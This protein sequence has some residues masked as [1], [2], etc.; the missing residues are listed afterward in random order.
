MHAGHSPAVN[1][2]PMTT[3]QNRLS[4]VSFA[5]RHF[6]TLLLVAYVFSYF[7]PTLGQLIRKPIFHASEVSCVNFMLGFV[8]LTLG[9][10]TSFQ[11][12]RLR[13]PSNRVQDCLELVVGQAK[14]V[15]F[16]YLVRFVVALFVGMLTS[17]VADSYVGI[18]VGFVLLC[19]APTAASS[20]SW[21]L[22]LDAS[23]TTTIAL[24]LGTTILSLVLGTGMLATVEF[25]ATSSC[26]EDLARLKQTFSAS[27][28]LPWV[29]APLLAGMFWRNVAPISA[30]KCRSVGVQLNPL[31]LL[32]LNYANAA[33]SFP[34]LANSFSVNQS[35]IVV[36][37]AVT[38]FLILASVSH[39]L[40]QR[41]SSSDAE[42]VSQTIGTSMSN[43]GLLLMMATLALPGRLDVHLPI[44]VYTFVQHLGVAR[45]R[46][47]QTQ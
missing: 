16:F 3:D 44:I 23:K 42:R 45:M 37:G 9:L 27:F 1:W 47:S 8:L 35:A 21:S 25:V 39:L 38:L 17:L 10:S 14:W 31:V 26:N 40:S 4:L 32:L 34:K 20:A 5:R 12:D 15:G 2:N 28:M 11:S 29:I 22:E 33:S 6:L 13:A 36:L 46:Y 19:A 30:E 41:V 24:I 43:T 7:F 18:L